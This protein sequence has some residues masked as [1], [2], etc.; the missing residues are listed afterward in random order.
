[1]WRVSGPVTACKICI[2]VLLLLA[3]FISNVDVYLSKMLLFVCVCACVCM[4]FFPSSSVL[5][6]HLC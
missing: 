1:M 3:K 6:K 2:K 5:T 4:L